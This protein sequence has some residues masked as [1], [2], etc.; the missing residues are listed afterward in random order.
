[1]AESALT[2]S[3]AQ[4]RDALLSAA[5]RLFIADGYPAMSMRKVAQECGV[6]LGHLQHFFPTKNSLLTA[7]L[8]ESVGEYTAAYRSFITSLTLGPRDR[9]EAVLRYLLA[10][11]RNPTTASFFIEL[12]SVALR[13]GEPAEV[14]QE[15][16]RYNQHSIEPFLSAVRPDLPEDRLR[17]LAIQVI[18]AVDGV[19]VYWHTD[20]PGDEEF[21]R[22]VEAMLSS[23][24]ATIEAAG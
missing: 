9:L 12:W 18:A 3:G 23:I 20:H 22:V 17:V 8:T 24:L 11:A 10:D 21:G 6:S 15:N 5:R 13:G 19:I 4:T 14:L 2:P 1:M 16:Y 7:M